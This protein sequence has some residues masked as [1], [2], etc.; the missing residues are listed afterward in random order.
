M[1]ADHL[2]RNGE[3][4][5]AWV[6]QCTGGRIV[7]RREHARW[8]PQW[9]LDVELPGGEILK[10]LLRGFR[11]PG[12]LDD[13]ASS[14]A[15]LKREAQVLK[16]LQN[17]GVK[18]PRYYGYAPSGDWFL[19][20]CVRG[21]YRLSLVERPDLQSEIFRQYIENI[22]LLHNLDPDRLDLPSTIYR[23]VSAA[24]GARDAYKQYEA[25][26][27]RRSGEP[28]PILEFAIWWLDHNAPDYTERFSLCTGDI[29]ANQFL[30]DG[31]EFTSIFDLE[32]AYLGDPLQDIGLMR[33]RAMLYPIRDFARQLRHYEVHSYRKFTMKSLNYWTVVGMLGASLVFNHL[34]EKPN[35]RQPSDMS[36]MFG[37]AIVRR[38]ACAEAFHEI[39]G[40][41]L[42][43]KPDRPE[44]THN[45][46]TKLNELVA[47]EI[48][49][50]FI[51]TAPERDKYLLNI[52][53]AQV[54]STGHAQTMGPEIA[55]RNIEDLGEALGRR[56]IDE[57][58][59]MRMLQDQIL[60]DPERNLQQWLGALYRI[61]ARNEYVYEPIIRSCEMAAYVP[62]E[63]RRV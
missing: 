59:G 23:P 46:F 26:Y 10:L 3:A 39:Y 18:V 63:P 1:S 41:P 61:E 28:A 56:P 22:A 38:R 48:E 52:L 60:A 42:P 19:M 6:E 32:M 45:S 33:Y 16:A 44:A 15:R 13:E 4:A 25:S 40:F 55:R 12:M 34:I 49:Q 21:D 37:A 2:N 57:R 53:L 54:E 5:L 47:A 35:P 11:N 62:F 50:L 51:P 36:H 14:R 24:E 9:F 30:F 27:R 20:E 43:A 17:T 8:R 29:G 58:Q 31:R 7:H